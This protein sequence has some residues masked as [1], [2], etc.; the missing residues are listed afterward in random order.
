V[1]LLVGWG[2]VATG[3]NKAGVAT[4]HGWAYG[5]HPRRLIAFSLEGNADLPASPLPAV[6]VPLAAR[7]FPVKAELAMGGRAQY[8]GACV[9]CHGGGAVAG[10]MAPDLRASGVVLSETGFADVVRGGARLQKG[11]PAFRELSDEQLLELRHYI[12][13]MAEAGLAAGPRQ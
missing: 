5:V 1:A 6:P 9:F 10:G 3:V 4:A 12:R 11:M 13:Q 7:E 2:G 8:E